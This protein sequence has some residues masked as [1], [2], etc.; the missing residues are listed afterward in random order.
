MDHTGNPLET[1]G[2]CFEIISAKL[3]RS[4]RANP[5]SWLRVAALPESAELVLSSTVGCPP[6]CGLADSRG[7]PRSNECIAVGRTTLFAFGGCVCHEGPSTAISLEHLILCAAQAA[8][9]DDAPACAWVVLVGITLSPEGVTL[10]LT[11]LL[12][13]LRGPCGA[14]PGEC[15]GEPVVFTDVSPP[16]AAASTVSFD[17][18][19][20][21]LRLGRC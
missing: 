2:Q 12:R 1:L 21:G 14:L 5:A 17:V 3:V 4:G 6:L 19:G 11:Q 20:R 8:P 13:N 9:P 18:D 7:M 10:A 16:I 15:T